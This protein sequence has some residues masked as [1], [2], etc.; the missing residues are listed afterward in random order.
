MRKAN[1]VSLK[2]ALTAMVDSLNM[3]QGLYQN[4]INH[5]WKEKMGT[6][7]AQH[8]REI[9]LYRRKLFLSIDSASLKQALSYSKEKIMEML[10][11]ELG[12]PYIVDVVIR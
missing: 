1:E 6:T 5:I 2:E 8:T 7:F 11:A 4:R 12:E 9:K 3:K 10:N